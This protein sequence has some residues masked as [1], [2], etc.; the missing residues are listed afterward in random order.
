MFTKKHPLK[1]H[2]HRIR[3]AG[4]R[5]PQEAARER[6]DRGREGGEGKAGRTGGDRQNDHSGEDNQTALVP[7]VAE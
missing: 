7:P 6:A 1:D 4:L 5:G 2:Q 3:K